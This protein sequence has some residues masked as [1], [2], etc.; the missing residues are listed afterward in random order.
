MSV[1]IV[2]ATYTDDD[3]KRPYS[4]ESDCAGYFLR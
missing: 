2:T 1:Y 3:Y 4:N